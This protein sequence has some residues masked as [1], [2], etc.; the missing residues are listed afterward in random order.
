MTLCETSEDVLEQDRRYIALGHC[1]G[2][3]GTANTTQRTLPIYRERIE[4]EDLP[5]TF[6]TAVQISRELEIRYLRID[7]LCICQDDT[8]DG[9]RQSAKMA[10]VCSNAS[11]VIAASG[12][13]NSDSVCFSSRP[14]LRCYRVPYTSRDHTGGEALA[15]AMDLK[16]NGGS[17]IRTSIEEGP[18]GTTSV[19]STRRVLA[20]CTLYYA[21]EQIYFECITGIVSED[22]IVLPEI[23]MGGEL[24]GRRRTK[25]SE[26]PSGPIHTQETLMRSWHELLNDQERQ[27]LAL[28]RD[29]FPALSG[30][31]AIARKQL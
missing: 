19:Y 16:E 12:I 2:G 8:K 15:S 26:F 10:D 22:G 14:Q 9:E 17:W 27:N 6:Q 18:V 4:L 20:K 13:P 23:Y 24:L 5:A 1:W 31:G 25:D 29:K 7:S 30:I 3:V 11:L 28:S 21:I